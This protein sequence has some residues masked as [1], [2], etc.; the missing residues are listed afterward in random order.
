MI[1]LA[2]LV[3][4]VLGALMA[5]W[6]R[7]HPVVV[8]HPGF[9]ASLAAVGLPSGAWISFRM[10]QEYGLLGYCAVMLAGLVWAP[11][12][13]TVASHHLSVSLPSWW[14]SDRKLR[15]PPSFDQGDGAMKAGDPA[16]ALALYRQELERAGAWPE[17]FLRMA[18]AHRALKDPAQAAAC[19]EEAARIAPEPAR[20]GPVLLALSETLAGAGR[21]EEA[22]GALARVLADPALKAYHAPAR[23]RQAAL[24]RA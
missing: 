15:V 21:K 17:L 18:D 2:W 1:A 16:R 13:A 22:A 7:R 3:F 9:L 19:L 24:A 4:A 6:A 5:F 8:E 12:L 14:M 11:Y 20:R 23:T 10:S